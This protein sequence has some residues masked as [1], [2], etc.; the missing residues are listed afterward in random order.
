MEPDYRRE[1]SILTLDAFSD[2]SWGDERST[3]RSTTL[4]MVFADGCL[5]LSICRAQ[6][7]IALS[8]CEAELYA[9]NST[10]VECIYLHQLAQFLMGSDLDVRQFSWT[11][12]L[13]SLKCSPTIRSGKAEA[14]GN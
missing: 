9:A 12:L 5:I 8:S 4:G 3:R 2:S 14:C 1:R 7:T 10:V 11:L 13:Q 6:A